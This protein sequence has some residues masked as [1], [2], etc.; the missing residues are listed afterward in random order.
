MRS[1]AWS[2]HSS[3]MARHTSVLATTS[4]A[5]RAEVMPMDTWSSRLAEVGMLSALA[6]CTRTLFSFTRLAAVTWAIMKPEFSPG[7]GVR[8][9]GRAERAGSMSCSTRRSEMLASSATAMARRSRARARGW[10]W[11][12]PPESMS[13]S[14]AKTR[15]LSV[16]LLISTSST[17]RT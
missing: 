11:K 15:G 8:K 13:P 12:F 6:G 14:S 16:A 3:S 9:A 10:P 5:L 4:R 17:R 1:T 7:F 2:P